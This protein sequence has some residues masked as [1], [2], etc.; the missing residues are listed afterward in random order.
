MTQYRY[1]TSPLTVYKAHP[2]FR[3][4]PRRAVLL[5][6]DALA[7]T[8]PTLPRSELRDRTHKSDSS[9]SRCVK[10]GVQLGLIDAD[11]HTVTLR[12]DWQDV[13]TNSVEAPA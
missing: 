10:L 1:S 9:L 11:R 2:F 6:V 4:G 8:G 7:L 13:V 3:G 5:I 12:P